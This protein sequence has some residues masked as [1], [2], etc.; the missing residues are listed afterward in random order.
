MA[1]TLHKRWWTSKSVKQVTA[2]A[3]SAAGAM[4]NTIGYTRQIHDR[5]GINQQQFVLLLI[6]WKICHC[7]TESGTTGESP[8]LFF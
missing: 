5:E 6:C 7:R 2:R 4:C 3:R 8:S 1:C